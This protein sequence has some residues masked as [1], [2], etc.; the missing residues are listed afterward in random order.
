MFGFFFSLTRKRTHS[1]SYEDSFSLHE[2]GPLGALNL[3]R[4]H[5]WVG[6]DTFQGLSAMA[7]LCNFP[8]VQWCG[9]SRALKSVLVLWAWVLYCT[10]CCTRS[11][12]I[13]LLN[14]NILRYLAEVKN[15][16][17]SSQNYFRFRLIFVSQIAWCR[18]LPAPFPFLS[19]F[20]S[21]FPIVVL[22]YQVCLETSLTF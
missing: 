9:E 5:G 19:F 1:C 11:I 20:L 15:I 10:R 2:Q 17:W 7:G 16:L 21:F 12:Q 4:S 8:V 13:T 6:T 3:F 22:C 14:I 18:Q